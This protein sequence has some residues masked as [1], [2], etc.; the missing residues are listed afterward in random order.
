MVSSRKIKDITYLENAVKSIEPKYRREFRLYVLKG[1]EPSRE[2]LNYLD[3]NTKAQG[4][5]EQAFRIYSVQ[6]M[7]DLMNLIG[8]D[9]IRNVMKRVRELG[10]QLERER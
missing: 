5:L 2:F 4:A 10:N 8:E 9:K 3:R 7:E 1:R 6:A